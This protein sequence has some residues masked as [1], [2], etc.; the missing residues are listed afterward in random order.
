MDLF[1]NN[2]IKESEMS[3]PLFSPLLWES[4]HSGHPPSVFQICGQDPLRDEGLIYERVLRE[5]EGVKTKVYV[6]PGQPHGFHSVAPTMK[7]SQKFI[8][9]SVDSIGW[10]L[11]QK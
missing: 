8:Q 9:D 6:Y 7:A 5:E 2:Y 11:E 1:M 3:N 10:L 4:G